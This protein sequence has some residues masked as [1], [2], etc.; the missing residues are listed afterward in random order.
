MPGFLFGQAVVG[1]SGNCNVSGDPNTI[2]SL[3]NQLGRYECWTA[4]DT[5]TGKQYRYEPQNSVGSRWVESGDAGGGGSNWTV[6]GSDIYRNTGNVGI[7]LTNPAYKLDVT[8]NIRIGTGFGLLNGSEYLARQ[9]GTNYFFGSSGNSTMTGGNNLASGTYAFLANTTGSNNIAY[10]S[11]SLDANTIGY[12]NAAIGGSAL[13]SNTEGYSNAAL[14]ADALGLNTTGAQNTAFGASCLYSNL[15]ANNNSGFG[16]YT[17]FYN[18]G[19]GNSAFGQGAMFK[20][21]TG[22]QNVAAGQSALYNSQTSNYTTALGHNSG[23]GGANY[24]VDGGTYC[25]FETGM[26]LLT[27]ANYNSLLGFRGGYTITTGQKNI[28]IGFRAQSGGVTTGS[29][30]ILIGDDVKYGLTVTGSD[31]MNI[32]NLLFGSGLAS[33]TTLASSGKIGIGINPPL[34]VLDVAGTARVTGVLTLGSSTVGTIRVSGGS[35]DPTDINIWGRGAVQF[36]TFSS[37]SPTGSGN[38]DMWFSSVAN[39]NRL[40]IKA[41]DSERSVAYLEKDLAGSTSFGARSADF[42][43]DLERN[44]IIDANGGA[45]TVKLDGDMVEGVDY[46]VKCRR[47]TSNNITFSASTFGGTIEFEGGSTIPGPATL[48]AGVRSVYIIVRIGTIFFVK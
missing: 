39:N 26:S 27:G 25:G 34:H 2:A 4:I 22:T 5:L 48:V 33:S 16:M 43:L 36:P 9:V 31:Q 12:N 18:T 29:R 35:K 8:G 42:D 41:D 21:T 19:A 1:G 40:K 6:S 17:L 37:G 24:G 20:N 11:S 7:G 10:G 15:T 32:G 47:N 13:G 3:N 28:D 46:R 23:G 14:G 45:I 38:G 44:A 30:N